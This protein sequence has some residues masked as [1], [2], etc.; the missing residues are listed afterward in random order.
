MSLLESS[1]HTVPSAESSSDNGAIS[2]SDHRLAISDNS[3]NCSQHD[4][5]SP[6]RSAH[7]VCNGSQADMAKDVG[8][9]LRVEGNCVAEP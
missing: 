4:L 3:G 8:A 5:K 7:K 2:H 9:L 6:L 1:S